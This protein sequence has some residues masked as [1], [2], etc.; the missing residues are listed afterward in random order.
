MSGK[1]RHPWALPVTTQTAIVV[2]LASITFIVLI[3][4]PLLTRVHL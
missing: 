4:A 2:V 1:R 3:A